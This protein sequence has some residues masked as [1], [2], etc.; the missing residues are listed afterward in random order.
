MH[1]VQLCTNH[2]APLCTTMSSLCTTMQHNVSIMYVRLCMAATHPPWE[3]LSL[4]QPPPAGQT[5]PNAPPWKKIFESEDIQSAK[6]SFQPWLNCKVI[7]YA[8]WRLVDSDINMKS[9]NL[10]MNF[11]FITTYFA[12]GLFTWTEP[13]L[14]CEPRFSIDFSFY[15]GRIPQFGGLHEVLVT[16]TLHI[17]TL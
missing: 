5:S 15:V 3:H 12:M 4:A 1:H 11:F 10:T 16:S 2:T 13:C 17:P 14:P 9:Q 6:G 7:R 8:I